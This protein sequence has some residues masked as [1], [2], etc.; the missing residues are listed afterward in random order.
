MHCI[1]TAAAF[2]FD[3]NTNLTHYIALKF[4]PNET[5]ALFVLLFLCFLD[6][7]GCQI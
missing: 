3:W 1:Q 4:K 7:I 6:I 5:P 2:H